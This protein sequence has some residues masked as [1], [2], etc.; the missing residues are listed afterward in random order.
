ME[1]SET[2]YAIQM[3]IGGSFYCNFSE[4]RQFEEERS[5]KHGKSKNSCVHVKEIDNTS[6]KGHMD[7]S[8]KYIYASTAR[9]SSNA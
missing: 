4:T 2:K 1:R 5:L 8:C 3:W 6:E 7:V 9:M